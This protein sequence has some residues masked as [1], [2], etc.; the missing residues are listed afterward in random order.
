MSLLKL[1]IIIFMFPIFIFVLSG[2]VFSL[3]IPYMVNPAPIL[4]Y[5]QDNFSNYLLK[6]NNYISTL[7]YSSSINNL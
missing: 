7:K 4:I 5:Y 1:F 6:F 2:L 3:I